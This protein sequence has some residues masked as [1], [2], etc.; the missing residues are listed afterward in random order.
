MVP[1]TD[2]LYPFVKGV[3]IRMETMNNDDDDHYFLIIGRYATSKA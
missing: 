2:H 3:E 1:S